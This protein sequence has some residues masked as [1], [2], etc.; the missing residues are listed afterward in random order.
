M[1]TVDGCCSSVERTR[2]AFAATSGSGTAPSGVPSRATGRHPRTFAALA[3]D[4]ARERLVLFGGNRVLFGTGSEKDPFLDDMWERHDGAWRQLAVP[5]PPARAEAS[6]AYDAARRRLVLFGG[7]RGTGDGRVRFGDT[8]EWDGLRWEER[9]PPLVPPARSGAAMAYDPDRRRV[10]LFGGSGR[11]A[12]TWEW[13][14]AVWIRIEAPSPARFNSVMAYDPGSRAL[15][16]F[17]G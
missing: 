15:L 13:D 17:G 9:T 14:G 10:V 16:R 3:Y 11:S 1:P 6:M 12:D 4:R 5:T 2:R 8:W 7:Y